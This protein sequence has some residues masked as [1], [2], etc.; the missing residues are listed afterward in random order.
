[1]KEAHEYN[2]A[3]AKVPEAREPG[4]AKMAPTVK[5]LT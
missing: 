5:S 1:M 4:E 2:Y 3:S